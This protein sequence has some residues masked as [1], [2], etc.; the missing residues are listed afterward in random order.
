MGIPP[1]RSSYA[2]LSQFPDDKYAGGGAPGSHSQP[3]SCEGTAPLG[4]L[5]RGFDWE[6]SA[7][8]GGDHRVPS[9]VPERKRSD[10]AAAESTVP[11]HLGMDKTMFTRSA[12]ED[13][14]G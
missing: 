8:G 14:G 11:L 2:P 6:S 7:G 1:R 10:C 4:R 3:L 9:R 12:A 13:E 5:D